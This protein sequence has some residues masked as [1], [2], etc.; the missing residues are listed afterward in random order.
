MDF[1]GIEEFVSRFVQMHA[2]HIRAAV[3]GLASPVAAL[4]VDFFCTTFFNLARDLTVPAYVY[5]TS[6]AS[7]LALFL[8]LPVLHDEVS[9][10]FEE[11]EGTVDVPGLP[12]VPPACL[13]T[14]L[15]DKKNP[16][17]TWFVYHGRRFTEADGVIMNMAS[18]LERTMIDAIADGRCTRG[19]PQA[20]YPVGPI[21]PFATRRRMSACG[22]STRS[23][24][25]PSSSSASGV[26]GAS[27]R[28]RR[29]R[30]R[31]GWS[32]AGS[33]SSGCCAGRRR[34]GPYSPRTQ[35]STRCSW[36]GSLGGRET[37]GSCG[38][39]GRRRRQSW[40]TPPWAAS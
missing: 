19:G 4:I 30:S 31:M 37:L 22:G 35:T 5:F 28:R 23:P 7:M 29:M 24:H 14:L 32:A 18:E 3:S 6:N 40:L 15:M 2:P 20:V 38:R 12:P 9:V 1:I 16:N 36:T 21:I 13:P 26:G 25:P 17:Y 33:A 39:R 8:R 10:E 34:R 27:P 11:M